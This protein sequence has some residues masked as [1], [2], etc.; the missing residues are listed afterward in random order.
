MFGLVEGESSVATKQVTQKNIVLISF[1]TLYKPT[2]G[3]LLHYVYQKM[4]FLCP[5]PSHF[6]GSSSQSAMIVLIATTICLCLPYAVCNH[7]LQS[8]ISMIYVEVIKK[9]QGIIN[10]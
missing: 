4:N 8:I 3:F 2:H 5:K 10:V 1:Q 6:R 9:Q 7:S